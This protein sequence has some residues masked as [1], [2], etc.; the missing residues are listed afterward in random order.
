MCLR[1]FG[2]NWLQKS[3]AQLTQLEN[4]DSLD[5][6]WHHGILERQAEEKT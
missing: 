5:E 2:G 6:R 1:S 3:G 4:M